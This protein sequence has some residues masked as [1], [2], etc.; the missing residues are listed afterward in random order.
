MKRLKKLIK[1]TLKLRARAG[2]VPREEIAKV[3]RNDSLAIGIE[4]LERSFWPSR[5]R[6]RRLVD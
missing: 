6:S 2:S 5:N 1:G 3:H 4:E